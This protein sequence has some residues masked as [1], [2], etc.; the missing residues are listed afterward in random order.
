MRRCMREDSNQA[1][2]C[3]KFGCMNVRGWG[4]GKFEDVCKE[5]S[6]WEFDLV[7]LTETHLRD[8]VRMEGCEYVM[9]GKGRAKQEIQGGGIALLY[10]KGRGLKVE[11]IDVGKCES[12][13]DVMAVSVECVG[14][15]GRTEKMVV[16]VVYMT[17]MSERAERE[18]R[19]K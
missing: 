15:S 18:N 13:E 5:L 10:K 3:V 6:V 19:R 2:E 1:S 12:S 8:E 16:V 14:G 17:V 9:I 7:G 11:E 4:V